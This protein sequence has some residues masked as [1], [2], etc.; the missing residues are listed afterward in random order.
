MHDF[1]YRF[2]AKDVAAE[3]AGISNIIFDLRARNSLRRKGNERM[4]EQL[5]QAA[6]VDSV[7]GS[8]AIEG[9]VTTRDRARDLVQGATQPMTHGEHEILGYRDALQEIYAP[10]FSADLSEDLV[11]HFHRLLMGSTSLEAGEYK[12]EDNWIQERDDQG[13]I[14][15]RFVPV[16]AGETPDAMTQ[17]IMAYREARQ[18]STIG[19][20]ALIACATV[21]FLCI[22]PFADGNGRVS[23]LL[24][25][26]LLLRSGFDV[27]R[28][29]SIEEM[30]NQHKTGYYDALAAS[31]DGWHDNKND[32]I[33]F[34]I[35]LL[36]ILYACY[37]ELDRR[38]VDGGLERVPKSRQV[39]ELLMAAFVPISKEE[40]CERLPDVS[41][42]TVTR[43]LGRLMREGK[44]EKIG[45]YRNARYR[46]L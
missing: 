28:Y 26:S 24:T 40:I 16:S 17:W 6:I 12:R 41:A 27:G 46:R 45:T 2:L 30:I 14:S 1:D 7:R 4:F 29:V 43:V 3:I 35:Y 36:Q 10:G 42:T 23:R 37:G 8:S 5:R 11:R 18:D 38:F 32:Y 20:L 21:D 33:P 19:D 13:R 34:I 31:S 39:E 15:V 44:V 25:T 9:I 22:H